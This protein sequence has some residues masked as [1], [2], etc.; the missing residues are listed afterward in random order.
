M[1]ISDWSSDVCSSDL[2]E[3]VLQNIGQNLVVGVA[4]A[5]CLARRRHLRLE[6]LGQFA[7]HLVAVILALFKRVLALFRIALFLV[8][9][10]PVLV[11]FV[12]P[13]AGRLVR[14]FARRIAEMRPQIVV[15]CA[16]DRSVEQRLAGQRVDS[17]NRDESGRQRSEEHTSELQSLMATSYAVSC[18]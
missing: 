12:L 1:R 6:Q 11:A 16:G 3:H 17:A 18:L 14:V 10:V 8:D 9:L 13:L 4:A 7:A 5:L 2:L 15:A